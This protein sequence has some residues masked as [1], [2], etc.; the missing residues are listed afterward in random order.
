MNRRVSCGC[1]ELRLVGETQAVL[2]IASFLS[3][4]ILCSCDK[5]NLFNILYRRI[6]LLEILNLMLLER[7]GENMDIVKTSPKSPIPP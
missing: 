5:A 6:T 4:F 2:D 7:F 3:F 1:S